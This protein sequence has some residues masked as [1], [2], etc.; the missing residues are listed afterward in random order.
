MI[1]TDNAIKYVIKHLF[2][3]AWKDV[4]NEIS[5]N[6][7]EDKRL[8][9]AIIKGKKIIFKISEHTHID[10]LIQGKANLSK[11]DTADGV[12]SIPICLENDLPFAEIMDNEL[13]V[14]ADIISLSFIML[15][16]YEEK[17]IDERDIHSRF[18]SKNSVAV[19]Y[20]FI[21][22]PIVDEYALIL[23]NYLK[24]L[25]PEEKIVVS[26]CNIIPTHDIDMVQ[27]FS[28]GL[29]KVV[30]SLLADIFL[31]KN[32][33]MFF[34]SIP[35]YFASVNNPDKDPY[36]ESIHKL[37]RVSEQFNLKSEFYFMGTQPSRMDC[38]YNVETPCVLR[39]LSFI[40]Q[41]EMFIGFHGGYYTSTNPELFAKEKNKIEA[42]VGYE[43]VRGRQH[44]LRFDVHSTFDIMEKCGIKYDSTLGYAD[45]EG[46]RCG[47]CYEYHP[48]DFE[49]D[50]EYNINE[51][52]LIVMDGTLSYYRVYTIEKA[53]AQMVKL[54]LRCKAVGGNFVLLWH[55]NSAM[56]ETKWFK[57]VYCRFLE[58]NIFES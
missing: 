33:F 18:E 44:Y 57:K 51:R 40:Q 47:T 48:Y 29:I 3:V 36:I 4:L 7:T 12:C 21:D 34:R 26:F 5:I 11:I 2:M 35:Q 41:H 58:N 16:R 20:N 22:F 8:A 10:Q 14:N 32:L 30:R 17:V 46:F 31:Y 23:Q 15:S 25:F 13:H 1:F 54:Y 45:R 56:R 27:R 39:T 49:N 43:I 55:N 24:V 19:K 9:V 52:P 37:V 38:G 50:R 28:G 53:Y 6:I 42:A